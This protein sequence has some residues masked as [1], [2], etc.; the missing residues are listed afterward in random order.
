MQRREVTAADHG[1]LVL[2]PQFRQLCMET[3]YT[4]VCE[5]GSISANAIER[6]VS[7]IWQ[8]V[9]VNLQNVA[10]G[11]CRKG[12]LDT[13]LG[14]TNEAQSGSK[15][16]TRNHRDHVSLYTRDEITVDR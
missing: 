12:G 5:N 9:Y 14:Q 15:R 7:F 16:A 4:G 6:D 3:N 13:V 8:W 1:V 11:H 2:S 10:C